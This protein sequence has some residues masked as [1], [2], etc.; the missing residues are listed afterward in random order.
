MIASMMFAAAAP[1][2]PISPI[3]CQVVQALFVQARAEG[4]GKHD[5]HVVVSDARTIHTSPQGLAM[6]IPTLAVSLDVPK[7]AAEELT[8]KLRT[9]RDLSWR[10]D[11]AWT[12]PPVGFANAFTRPIVSGDGRLAITEWSSGLDAPRDVGEV[13]LAYRPNDSWRVSCIMSWER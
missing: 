4:K 9:E 7:R 8:A 12:A 5:G 2:A 11:C 1:V 6:W 13:C 10:G 3:E